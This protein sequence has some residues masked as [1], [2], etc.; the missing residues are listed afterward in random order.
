MLSNAQSQ[1]ISPS[2]EFIG[3]L[4]HI[5]DELEGMSFSPAA[6]DKIFRLIGATLTLMKKITASSIKEESRV[7]LDSLL[8]LTVSLKGALSLP[9]EY[10]KPIDVSLVCIYSQLAKLSTIDAFES[11]LQ[12][13]ALILENQDM[14]DACKWIS[15]V[16]Y[17]FGGLAMSQAAFEKAES[18][19][20][21]SIYWLT[22]SSSNEDDTL[23]K[24][25]ENLALCRFKLRKMN[26][27]LD[28]VSLI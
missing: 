6:K 18:F 21:S 13:A 17:N 24:R 10:I 23:A 3:Q 1:L 4:K 20:E 15:S 25:Y 16:Y 5:R 12:N 7:V 9:S 22:R 28:E 14:P 26:V 2:Q 11:Y 27:R 8:E 19:F